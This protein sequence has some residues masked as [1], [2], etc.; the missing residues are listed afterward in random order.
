MTLANVHE[1]FSQ[2]AQVSQPANFNLNISKKIFL[3]LRDIK[4]LKTSTLQFLSVTLADIANVN[5]ISF[6]PAKVSQNGQ[7]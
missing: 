1:I 6:K 4:L 7:I 5:E 2:S 3:S